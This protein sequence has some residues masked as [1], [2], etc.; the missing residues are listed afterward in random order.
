MN[1]RCSFGSPLGDHEYTLLPFRFFFFFGSLV[2]DLNEVGATNTGLAPRLL[3]PCTGSGVTERDCM[4]RFALTVDLTTLVLSPTLSLR[5][6]GRAL[7]LNFVGRC[8]SMLI[9][10]TTISPSNRHRVHVYYQR[11]PP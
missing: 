2:V 3:D 9:Q 6:L 7:S 4:L 1:T 8:W 11:V 5:G 10:P